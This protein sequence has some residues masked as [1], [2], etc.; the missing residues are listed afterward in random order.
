[1]Q[2]LRELSRRVEAV[3]G[4]MADIYAGYQQVRGL[5]CRSG[6]GACC[7]HPEIEAS[8]LDMLP[9]AMHLFDQGTAESTLAQLEAAPAG[10]S[11]PMYQPL[12]FDGKQ[13]QCRI[14]Q[15]RPTLCRTFGAAGYRDKHGKTAL[16]T[17][18]TIKQER[19][20]AYAETLIAMELDPPPMLSHARQQVDQLD[21]ELSRS[22]LPI[23]EAMQLAL[24][25]VLFQACY[26]EVAH[27]QR[28]A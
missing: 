19:S 23:A 14:Y 13:G 1:M 15:W 11:C 7:L 26:S 3:Y 22:S 8:V 5:H 20:S 4:E 12:S 21:Y 28:I 10:N 2:R 16:S 27:D 9:L 25:K 6:C 18:K 17:C 24:Y